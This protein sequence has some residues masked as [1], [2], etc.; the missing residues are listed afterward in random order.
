MR[1]AI[2]RF[3]LAVPTTYVAVVIFGFLWLQTEIELFGIIVFWWMIP[4]AFIVGL[5]EMLRQEFKKEK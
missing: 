3:V 4:I 1:K 2:K 5:Y